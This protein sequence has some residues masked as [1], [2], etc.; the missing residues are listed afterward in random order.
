MGA[1][2]AGIEP[3]EVRRKGKKK[4]GFDLVTHDPDP[5][6]NI[7]AR[8]QRDQAVIEANDAV[9]RQSAKR[10]DARSVAVA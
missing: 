6:F 7:I 2:A 10:R 3:V 5:L 9:L 1:I 8:L 4:I